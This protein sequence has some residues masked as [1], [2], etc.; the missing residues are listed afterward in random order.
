MCSFTVVEVRTLKSKCSQGHSLQGLLSSFWWL[1]A[2]LAFLGLQPH[3]PNLC[4]HLCVTD[5]LCL[6][7][8]TM[9]SIASVSKLPSS[10]PHWIRTRPNPPYSHRRDL[11]P[12]KTFTGS[13]EPPPALSAWHSGIGQGKQPP[14]LFC[15]AMASMPVPA[16]SPSSW[17]WFSDLPP[18][19]A[20]GTHLELSC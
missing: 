12:Y 17:P 15:R 5:S 3:H 14:F 13:G 10:S 11:L 16:G 6:C 19:G 18:P 20:S 2:T 7:L 4:L 9:V 1:L 8:H